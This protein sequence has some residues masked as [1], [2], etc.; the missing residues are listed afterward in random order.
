MDVI[1]PRNID[2]VCTPQMGAPTEQQYGALQ[3]AYAR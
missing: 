2:V 3:T 1:G